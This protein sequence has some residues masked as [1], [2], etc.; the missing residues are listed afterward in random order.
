MN[1]SRTWCPKWSYVLAQV[2]INIMEKWIIIPPSFFGFTASCCV[3]F[4]KHTHW[5]QGSCNPRKCLETEHCTFKQSFRYL[6][7]EWTYSWEN[8][9]L[10]QKFSLV[11]RRRWTERERKREEEG[12]GE[13]RGGSDRKRERERQMAFPR[14]LRRTRACPSFRIP[15]KAFKKCWWLD[16]ISPSCEFIWFGNV[17]LLLICCQSSTGDSYVQSGLT[18]TKA[19]VLESLPSR[20]KRKPREQRQPST[21]LW[22][23]LRMALQSFYATTALRGTHSVPLS[24]CFQSQLKPSSHDQ[25]G[26]NGHHSWADGE[27]WAESPPPGL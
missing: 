15:W 27:L 23:G 22:L 19:V 16:C 7:G 24:L 20:W 12:E 17:A 13:G 25:C 6:E 26:A 10:S 3:P 2:P 14:E 9:S 5:K 18:T 11:G 8:K 21:W 1:E 4:Y